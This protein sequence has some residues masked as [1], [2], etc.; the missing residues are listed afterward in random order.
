M[1]AP[2]TSPLPSSLSNWLYACIDPS[3]IHDVEIIQPL[4]NGYGYCIRCYRNSAPPIVVKAVLVPENGHTHPKGWNTSASDARKR[5][6]FD[7]EQRF[8]Q[9]YAARLKGVRVAGLLN[10]FEKPDGW[11]F[12]L[13]DLNAAGFDQ[14]ASSLTFSQAT[15]VIE[16]LAGFHACFLGDK[17]EGLWEQGCYWHLATR[18]DELTAM[19]ECPL[20]DAAAELDRLLRDCPYQTIVHGDAKVANFCFTKGFGHCAGLDF[21]YTGRGPGIIDI[22]YFI[23]SAFEESQ[24][25]QYESSLLQH[26]FT[27][28]KR[29]LQASL[30]AEAIDQVIHAWQALYPVACADFLR[31]I[32]GW[33]PDHWKNNAYLNERANAGLTTSGYSKKT[34]R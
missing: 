13:E 12:M 19:A 21:Q 23:G 2:R 31:F 34:K 22:A 27:A 7:V 30:P 11:L 20:K 26:Y 4:W 29:E 16:W 14:R 18:Q 32:M 17:G 24:L 8:Y 10:A 33:C 28:L 3:D 15:C 25:Q 1:S 5:R 6:S 9:K